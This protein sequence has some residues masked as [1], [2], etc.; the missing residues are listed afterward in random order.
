MKVFISYD[1]EM[2]LL[3][4]KDNIIHLS[5]IYSKTTHACNVQKKY[6]VTVSS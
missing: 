3:T 6:V 5:N 2:R 1:R 4:H